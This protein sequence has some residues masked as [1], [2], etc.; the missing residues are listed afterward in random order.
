MP[1]LHSRGTT[2][3]AAVRFLDLFAG[4]GGMSLG[5]ERSGWEVAGQ[6]EVDPYCRNI[7]RRHWPHVWQWGDVRLLDTIP[8]PVDAIVGGFPC[9]DISSANTAGARAGLSGRK[10]GLWG[11]FRRLVGGLRPRVVLV[12]N[13]PRWRSWVPEVRADLA[14]LG[15]ASLPLVVSAGFVGA[16]HARPRSFVVANAH[17]DGESWESFDA[18]VA[19]LRAL[20]DEVWEWPGRPGD[21]WMDDGVSGWL[22][23]ELRALGNA[24]VPQVAEVIGRALL[25]SVG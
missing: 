21:I 18:E 20:P 16:P 17:G 14:R 8:F 15:Y 19:R 7:L 22:E 23:H 2:S 10:S 1:S 24:V 11:E 9:Q 25:T 13:S 3:G 5:L 12:E 6:V 4:I